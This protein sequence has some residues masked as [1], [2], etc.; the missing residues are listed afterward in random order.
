M[1]IVHKLCRS[2]TH[3]AQGSL[4]KEMTKMKMSTLR[5]PG[6]AAQLA[7]YPEV[8]ELNVCFDTANQ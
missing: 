5:I 6:S 3:Q 8:Q 1:E 2:S 4:P 7:I